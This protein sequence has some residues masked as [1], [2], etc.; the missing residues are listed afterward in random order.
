[1]ASKKLTPAQAGQ[2]GGFVSARLAGADGMAERG[3]KGGST[4]VERY[5]KEHF[6]RA[7]H[8]RWGRLRSPKAEQ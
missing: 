7:A 2:L 5:G 4:T 8:A 3:S 6:V 1:M